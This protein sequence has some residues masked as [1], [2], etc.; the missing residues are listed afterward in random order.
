MANTTFRQ[1][2]KVKITTNW[3]EGKPTAIICAFQV[4]G[5]VRF[6]RVKWLGKARSLSD[7]YGELF[8]LD[9]LK[10]I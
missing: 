3:I 7:E 1:G 2:D 6:A 10:R 8:T 4:N 5:G 9:E